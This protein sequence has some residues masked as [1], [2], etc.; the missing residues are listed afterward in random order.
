MYLPLEFLDFVLERFQ[1][2]V[3]V[4]LVLLG[5]TLG[6]IFQNIVCQHFELILQYCHALHGIIALGI[7]DCG[8]FGHLIAH[9]LLLCVELVS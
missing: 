1:Q 6:F 8:Q 3:E 5:K 4:G 9:P 2:L 7:Q